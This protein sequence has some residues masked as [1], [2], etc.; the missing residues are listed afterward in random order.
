VQKYTSL[1]CFRSL[2][3]KS[4]TSYYTIPGYLDRWINGRYCKVTARVC[5]MIFYETCVFFQTNARV[6]QLVL[7][8]VSKPREIYG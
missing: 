6:L 2:D 1:Q 3:T 8:M 5:R 4:P 7:N